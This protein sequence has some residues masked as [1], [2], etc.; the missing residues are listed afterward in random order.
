LNSPYSSLAH[1]LC[2]AF[3]RYN[4]AKRKNGRSTSLPK[5]TE[6]VGGGKPFFFSFATSQHGN[7]TA[8]VLR[9]AAALLIAPLKHG[10]VKGVYPR[11]PI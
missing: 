4:G 5:S 11:I 8:P 6:L 2:G 1:N 7:A 10:T 9:S 3:C